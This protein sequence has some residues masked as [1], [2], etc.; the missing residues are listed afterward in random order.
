MEIYKML[1]LLKNK[2]LINDQAELP[3][4]LQDAVE[5]MDMTIDR[6]E[7]MTNLCLFKMDYLE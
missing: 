2:I 4:Y 3:A 5:K 6:L 7:K 1:Q